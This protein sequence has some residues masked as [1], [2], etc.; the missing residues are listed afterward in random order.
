[1]ELAM[2]LYKSNGEWMRAYNP[3]LGNIHIRFKGENTLDDYAAALRGD[4]VEFRTIHHKAIKSPTQKEAIIIGSTDDW[5]EH[6][7]VRNVTLENQKALFKNKLKEL[8]T[9]NR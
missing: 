4:M 6:V 2:V 9:K 7:F 3:R 1:M 5:Q 8:N